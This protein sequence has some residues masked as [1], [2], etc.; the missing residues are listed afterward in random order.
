MNCKDCIHENKK[1]YCEN[2]CCD[3]ISHFSQKTVKSYWADITA[4]NAKQEQKGKNK[5]GEM[6]ENNTTLT[7]EQ[8][9]EH[10]EEEL[11]NALKYCEHLKQAYTDKLTANDYQ[12]A[13]MRT[14]GTYDSKL[15]QLRNSAYGL[16]GEA[17]EVIDLLKKHEFQ[18][19]TLDEDKILDE[20]GDVAWYIAIGANAIGKT[21]EEVFQHNI[22]KLKKRYPDGFDKSRSVNRG[23]E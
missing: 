7:T 18:G 17:G 12:R 9:I 3:G 5:Y 16:N 6:L 20:L 23:N 10:L 13:A 19:H 21:L 22:D 14:A 15:S 4:L 8:R 11:I 2:A 1:A